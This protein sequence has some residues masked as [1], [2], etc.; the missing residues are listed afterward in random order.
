VKDEN[1]DLADYHNILNGWKNYSQLLN[2]RT[3]LLLVPDPSPLRLKFLCNVE[4]YKSPGSD[5]ILAY[6]IQTV[7][8]EIHELIN[9]ICNKRD[10]MISRRSLLFQ[11][12][13]KLI[14][15]LQ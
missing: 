3:A 15:C 8:S 1:G 5:Q 2:I 14:N 9:L 13:N 10:F 4:K 11:F 7:V 6:M 12:T